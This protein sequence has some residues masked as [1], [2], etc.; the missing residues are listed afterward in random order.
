MQV[1]DAPRGIEAGEVLAQFARAPAA[2]RLP[3]ASGR[4]TSIDSASDSCARRV[5]C[6]SGMLTSTI[7]SHSLIRLPIW[8]G[9][10]PTL[11]SG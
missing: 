5:P 8:I 11:K 1:V 4:P 6:C 10:T 2:R 3:C 7:S 9:D